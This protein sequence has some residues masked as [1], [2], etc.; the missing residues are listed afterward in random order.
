MNVSIGIPREI[1][2]EAGCL[3][4]HVRSIDHG[5]V[6]AVGNVPAAMAGATWAPTH[7]WAV[8]F[9]ADGSVYR[10]RHLLKSEGRREPW[11]LLAI[12]RHAAE[13]PLSWQIVKS[14]HQLP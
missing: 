10:C 6:K 12:M 4:V 14:T 3:C 5:H 7:E 1:P 9:W 11:S 8:I 2:P 13:H